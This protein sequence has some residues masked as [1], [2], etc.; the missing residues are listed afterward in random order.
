VADPTHKEIAEELKGHWKR[1]WW[2]RIDDKA[3]VEG[4]FDRDG[5][6]GGIILPNPHVGGWRKFVQWRLRAKT[7][8]HKLDRQNSV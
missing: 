1:L 2:E 5:N 3:R 8:I 7:S 4:I 6:V